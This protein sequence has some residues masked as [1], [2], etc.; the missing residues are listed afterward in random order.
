[1][2]CCVDIA[3]RHKQKMHV[4]DLR[5]AWHRVSPSLG[6]N[7]IVLFLIACVCSDVKIFIVNFV[8]L[9]LCHFVITGKMLQTSSSC[10]FQTIDNQPLRHHSSVT[11]YLQWGAG[12]GLYACR[13]LFTSDKRG[14]TWFCPCLF[15]CL[16]VC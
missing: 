12:Q 14:A 4:F 8:T 1:M 2:S 13:R 15:V 10:N 16:S 7:W 6:D 5:C 9:C 11:V 3:A